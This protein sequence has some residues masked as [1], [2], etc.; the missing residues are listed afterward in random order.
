MPFSGQAVVI[1]PGEGAIAA[2]RG[3]SGGGTSDGTVACCTVF[4]RNLSY[5]SYRINTLLRS[6][7]TLRSKPEE[8]KGIQQDSVRLPC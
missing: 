6:S 1:F 5:R 8:K 3:G 7:L 4:C 2:G